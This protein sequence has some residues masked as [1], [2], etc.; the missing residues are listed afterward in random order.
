[1]TYTF[2]PILD[3][4]VLAMDIILLIKIS[5]LTLKLGG[6]CIRQLICE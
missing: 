1:M 5:L 2:M 4:L 6:T 3:G